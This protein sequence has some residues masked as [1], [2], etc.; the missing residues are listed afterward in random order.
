MLAGKYRFRGKTVIFGCYRD[1]V[2]MPGMELDMTEIAVVPSPV[3][4][5]YGSTH[6]RSVAA[7]AIA[8]LPEIPHLIITRGFPLVTAT[9]RAAGSIKVVLE[10]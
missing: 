6:D 1:A 2:E 5:R 10:P 9:D 7:A 3:Q 4:G 8:Q